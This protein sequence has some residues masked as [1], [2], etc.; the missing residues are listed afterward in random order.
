MRC[1]HLYLRSWA[2]KRESFTPYSVT[3]TTPGTD[4][5]VAPATGT[6]LVEIWGAGGN[7]KDGGAAGDYG[8]GGGAYAKYELE[9]IEEEIY[10]YE[11]DH[12]GGATGWSWFINDSKHW[13]YSGSSNTGSGGAEI[14][15]GEG[16]ENLIVSFAG[17]NGYSTGEPL[18]EGPLSGFGGGASAS[19]SGAGDNGDDPTDDDGT[20]GGVAA[21]DGGDGGDGGAGSVSADGSPGQAGTQPG[22]GGGGGGGAPAGVGGTGGAGAAGQIRITRIA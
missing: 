14:G 21:T 20:D 1:A 17:G 8:G 5:Y 19:P 3:L 7:G 2:K 16:A 15:G 18:G 13:S 22:G 11:I 9:L 12:N 6:F 10:P 4:N